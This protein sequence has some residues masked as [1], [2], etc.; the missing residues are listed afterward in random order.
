MLKLY[1]LLFYCFYCLV[2]KRAN[3]Q[4]HVRA[5][6]LQGLVLTNFLI[7]IFLNV[8]YLYYKHHIL[9]ALIITVFIVVPMNLLVDKLEN[10]FYIDN[11]KYLFAIRRFDK[12]FTNN[13]K[14]ILALFALLLILF[15]TGLF[16]YTGIKIGKETSSKF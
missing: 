8:Y 3:D 2:I 1:D 16:I 9:K 15:S 14:K 12:Y 13:Q 5:I 4:S 10:K 6:M 7:C 11:E